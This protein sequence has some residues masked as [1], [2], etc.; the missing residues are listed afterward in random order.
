M[1]DLLFSVT[2]ALSNADNYIGIFTY[3]HIHIIYN[4]NNIEGK[5]CQIPGVPGP[6]KIERDCFE[7]KLLL[8]FR[9]PL[10]V[11]FHKKI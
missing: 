11:R 4:I 2:R 7:C 6:F 5:V 9:V 8:G 10:K 1:D 3:C